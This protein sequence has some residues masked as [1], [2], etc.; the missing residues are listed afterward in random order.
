MPP[1]HIVDETQPDLLFLSLALL[2]VATLLFVVALASFHRARRL[3]KGPGS[4]GLPRPAFDANELARITVADIMVPRSEVSGIDLDDDMD[5]IMTTLCN[6]Q[7]TRL[8][9]YTKDL[10]NVIGILHMRTVPR[11][12]REE[13]PPNKAELVQLSREPY[14]IPESTPLTT[15]LV[16]FQKQKRSLALVV[17]E[18]GEVKGL[19][20]LGDL[21]EELVSHFTNASATESDILPQADGSYLIDGATPIRD[22]NRALG[23][24]LPTDG[25]KTLNGLLTELL[26]SIPDS[27]VG[28]SLPQH[29]VEI[30]QVK[31]NLIKT[32][33][34]WYQP[35][36][37]RKD[38][39]TNAMLHD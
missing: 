14:F 25:P 2:I 34:M 5:A 35:P 6:S 17:D 31:D 20:T 9:V 12:L 30:L 33:R 38:I 28:L 1:R 23:W 3:L 22:I 13:E 39:D 11:L 10:N 37:E 21:L 32:V 18:Y 24:D 29:R 27:Q 7:H 26:E 36:L 8:P 15:Q 19:V 4:A 16:N